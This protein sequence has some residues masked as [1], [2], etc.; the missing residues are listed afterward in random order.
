MPNK[1]F[2]GSWRFSAVAAAAVSSV[3][4]MDTFNYEHLKKN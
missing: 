4:R 3:L 1:N 2:G